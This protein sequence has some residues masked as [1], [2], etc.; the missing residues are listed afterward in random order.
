MPICA[1]SSS[2]FSA[3]IS[4]TR[5]P[6]YARASSSSRRRACSQDAAAVARVID[7]SA[8][9]MSALIDDILDFARARLGPGLPIDP[10][11]V[12]DLEAVLQRCRQR[13]EDACIRSG[14]FT[15]T[16]A[17]P[18]RSSAIAA[19]SANCLANLLVNALTHGDAEG[20]VEVKALVR[21]GR[22]V[23]EVTNRGEPMTAATRARLFQPFA[24]SQ[25]IAAGR[26]RPR[27]VHRLGD[28]EGAP[29]SS[30]TC[31]RL[32]RARRPVL[33]RDARVVARARCRPRADEADLVSSFF[34]RAP[35]VCFRG[36]R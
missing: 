16:S 4:A 6:P 5:W 27:T 9:R 36:A 7:R 11:V 3:T 32:G 2:P 25:S 22:F 21:D 19:A 8:A 24:R 31:T 14:R 33:V 35:F 15:R 13:G 29:R 18:S 26:A 30:S 23:L 28:R 1:S 10:R 34:C 17:C 12:S 20:P